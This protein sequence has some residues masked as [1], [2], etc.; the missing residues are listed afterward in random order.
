MEGEATKKKPGRYVRSRGW[1]TTVAVLRYSTLNMSVGDCDTVPESAAG[2]YDYLY[3]M[4][5]LTQRSPRR[6]PDA[7]NSNRIDPWPIVGIEI[8]G[9]RQTDRAGGNRKHFQK[10]LEKRQPK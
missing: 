2:F 7:S 1:W 9:G 6:V 3:F 10:R 5:A 4:N 8:V